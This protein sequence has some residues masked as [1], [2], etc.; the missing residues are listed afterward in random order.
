MKRAAVMFLIMLA[1]L[2]TVVAQDFKLELGAN[3]GVW[4]A[5]N[6]GFTSDG[7]LSVSFPAK[8]EFSGAYLSVE[9]GIGLSFFKDG[10]YRLFGFDIAGELGY[11]ITNKIGVGIFGGYSGYGSSLNLSIPSIP[12]INVTKEYWK[13]G[14]GVPLKFIFDIGLGPM[15]LNIK[16]FIGVV[17]QYPINS[18]G[19]PGP[20]F[21]LPFA[22]IKFGSV[23]FELPEDPENKAME[24][25]KG[26]KIAIGSSDLN[27]DTPNIIE[28]DKDEIYL[29]GEAGFL[30][31]YEYVGGVVMKGLRIEGD[32]LKFTDDIGILYVKDISQTSFLMKYVFV[33]VKRL[34]E[35]LKGIE[36]KAESKCLYKAGSELK[37]D[38]K[39]EVLGVDE[40]TGAY[41]YKFKRVEE[42]NFY[43]GGES[44]EVEGKTD[45]IVE[46]K[47]LTFKLGESKKGEG[48][49]VY[50]SFIKDDSGI[51]R[52]EI[53]GGHYGD[54]IGKEV[55]KL[56]LAGYEAEVNWSFND[57]NDNVVS[58][59]IVVGTVIKNGKK[60][61]NEKNV[62]VE[63]DIEA[64]IENLVLLPSDNIKS[65]FKEIVLLAGDK[66]NNRLVK[67]EDD[68]GNEAEMNIAMDIDTKKAGVTK[69]KLNLRFK[70][71]N[72]DLGEAQIRIL[73]NI[74]A[75][76]FFFGKS[77]WEGM[78]SLEEAMDKKI[79]NGI[80][81]LDVYGNDATAYVKESELKPKSCKVNITLKY[82][83]GRIVANNL[84]KAG[85]FECN[86]E[87]KVQLTADAKKEYR[88]ANLND[89]EFQN[90]KITAQNI[91]FEIAP[92]FS[93]VSRKI[94]DVTSKAVRSL[95][96]K[97]K[98]IEVSDVYGNTFTIKDLRGVLK[99][100]KSDAVI[101]ITDGNSVK[102]TGV[103]SAT[104]EKATIE[105]DSI[106]LVSP[107][108][109][110]LD[111]YVL[112]SL[113]KR[114]KLY[115]NLDISPA[116]PDKAFLKRNG[117]QLS[118]IT[119]PTYTPEDVVEVPFEI[120]VYDEFDNKY[121]TVKDGLITIKS[122]GVKTNPVKEAGYIKGVVISNEGNKDITVKDIKVMYKDKEIASI[123][124]KFMAVA[125]RITS[126]D[127]KST[128][129]NI[130]NLQVSVDDGNGHP[131]EGAGVEVII[132]K[133]MKV[134][135]KTNGEG[136]FD[137]YVKLGSFGEHEVK[138]IVTPL[139]IEAIRDVY[140]PKPIV[141][142]KRMKITSSVDIAKITLEKDLSNLKVGQQALAPV[143]SPSGKY[144]AYPVLSVSE[145]EYEVK[146]IIQN[147]E[148]EEKTN[149][150]A[151]KIKRKGRSKEKNVGKEAVYSY[152]WHPVRD[153][154]I[155][156]PFEKGSFNIF[157]YDLK[158][159]DKYEVYTSDNNDINVTFNSLGDRMV[160][161]SAGVVMM[162]SVKYDGEKVTIRNVRELV[163]AKDGMNLMA[164]VSPDGKYV[165]YV[166]N[167][168]LF[169]FDIEN[170]KEMK[171]TDSHTR[172]KRDI[173]WSQDSKKVA[174]YIMKE[175]K[176]E[177]S[178]AV[179]DLASKKNWIAYENAN[180]EYGPVLWY[181]SEK[182]IFAAT[183]K[184]IEQPLLSY[185]VKDNKT[186]EVI[187]D[188][189]NRA[190]LFKNLNIFADIKQR[191]V[192]SVYRAFGGKDS[193]YYGLVYTK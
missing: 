84:T 174:Y 8:Y 120:E 44:V 17:T 179:Y 32:L 103:T 101:N 193:I 65:S 5:I 192:F 108:L 30:K 147:I 146:F 41:R 24:G 43:G 37:S 68:Y 76:K 183:D 191:K 125:K 102:L 64:T 82:E 93:S 15:S 145:G 50:I 182:F 167:G 28:T 9:P 74:K 86:F 51:W 7:A 94:L 53:Q 12:P 180:P 143:V 89:K 119:L 38:C 190:I 142:L 162:A 13:I 90:L 130:A 159:N 134:Q 117:M 111:E 175:G 26:L 139:M 18:Q 77:L 81:V 169:I 148:T 19:I 165:A 22:G 186:T 10:D 189:G 104:K 34:A 62:E 113:A 23:F 141:E 75:L 11:M 99:E 14:L 20:N 66:I 83:K 2:G 55:Y 172:P 128:L 157:A 106:K 161:N 87:G 3:V 63:K 127:L 92:K 59:N 156:T 36:I 35:K 49:E 155:Y 27:K 150:F 31:E 97:V 47:V 187:M 116:E 60:E 149:I 153:V 160:W 173:S 121:P 178:L 177:Y 52:A 123:A 144:V 56:N 88:K 164:V 176:D 152:T 25:T 168:D 170:S 1:I 33:N 67:V 91:A 126:I 132:D 54:V 79:F 112:N 29:G 115:V 78:K 133:V 98:P 58:K 96:M 48:K 166:R 136:M 131:V 69:E 114:M 45:L 71:V 109:E 118:E 40:I 72:Y 46:Y 73:P 110:G 129:F 122:E 135:G 57:V 124:V 138:V 95:S 140:K 154:L 158:T 151:K 100:Y 105:I 85:S 42:S 137:F 171:I 188:S 21:W 6:W 61:L 181:T 80:R 184:P 16:P 70:D 4:D 185:N 163:G 39:F 107:E